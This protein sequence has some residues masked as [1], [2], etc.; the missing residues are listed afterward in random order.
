MPRASSVTG[1]ARPGR[2]PPWT[3]PAI[4]RQTGLCSGPGQPVQSGAAITRSPRVDHRLG[5][6]TC[7]GHRR[8]RGGPRRA[9]RPREPH[10]TAACSHEHGAQ[11]GGGAGANDSAAD[12][13]HRRE[14]DRSASPTP[15]DSTVPAE[16]ALGNPAAGQP[17][18]L[19]QPHPRR[20]IVYFPKTAWFQPD[21]AAAQL[22]L[23]VRR[24]WP[25]SGGRGAVVLDLPGSSAPWRHLRMASS[26]RSSRREWADGL[27][28]SPQACTKASTG[29]TEVSSTR[30]S[31]RQKEERL[32]PAVRGSGGQP[33]HQCRR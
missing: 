15:G 12:P 32:G 11:P 33:A 30:A 7:D 18:P 24:G 27:H 2:R 5:R 4:L 21:P 13:G 8:C 14:P 25:G 20:W 3:I 17:H 22:Q 19:R 26:R 10:A 29:R 6:R 9:R 23:G 31:R 28:P 1:M 16:C